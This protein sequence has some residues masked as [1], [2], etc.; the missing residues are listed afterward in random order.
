[1][2]EDQRTA[3]AEGTGSARPCPKCGSALAPEAVLCV[4]CGYHLGHGRVLKSLDAR[5]REGPADPARK[6]L[7]AGGTVALGVGL[8]AFVGVLAFL[9]W[10]SSGPPSIIG[11]WTGHAVFE[12]SGRTIKTKDISLTFNKDG[13][14]S[15]SDG[16]AGT[17]SI[18]GD[19]L[20]IKLERHDGA[21]VSIGFDSKFTLERNFLTIE[22]YPFAPKPVTFQRE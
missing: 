15:C 9:F 12:I 2:A 3:S 13:T 6:R 11:T 16:T 5:T 4:S 19:R 20:A 14:V 10:L 22:E 18:K 17:Y 7:A 21:N 1:M 8:L